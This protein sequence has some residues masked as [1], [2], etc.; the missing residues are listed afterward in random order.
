VRVLIVLSLSFP[1]VACGVD[2]KGYDVGSGDV[3]GAAYE[4]AAPA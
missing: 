4:E 1:L 3:D 2:P